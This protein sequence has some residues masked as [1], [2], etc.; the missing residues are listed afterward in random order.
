MST[1][2]TSRRSSQPPHTPLVSTPSRPERPPSPLSPTRESRNDEKRSMQNLNDRLA[3]YIEAVR[4]REAEIQGLKQERT[5]IEETHHT[6][7]T[8]IKTTYNK[9]IGVLRKALDKTSSENSRLQLAADKGDRESQEAKSELV[10]KAR[11][12]EI[13][14]REHKILQESFSKLKNKCNNAENELKSLKPENES[15]KKRLDETKKSLEDET[16]KRVDL[17]NE[18]LSKEESMKFENQMLEQQLNE[19]KTKK[20]IEISELD[21]RLNEQY[22]A[23]MQQSLNE[24]RD[25]YE[26]QIDGNQKEFQRVY[27]DKLKN[28]Q[29]RLDAERLNNAGSIQEVRELTTKITALTNRNVE[30]ESSNSSLQKRMTELQREMDDLAARTRAE[31]ARKDA[32]VRNKEE[33][34]DLMT[35]DYKDLMEIK[36]ALDMEIAAYRKLLEGEE[37]R[38]GLSPA[39]SPEAS[40]SGP[41]RKRKRTIFEEEVILEMVSEH[42]G[43]GNVTI[44]PVTKGANN[45]CIKNN[46]EEDLNIGGWSLVNETKGEEYSYKFPARTSLK[47][48]ELCTVWSADSDQEHKPPLNLVFK[49]GGWIIGIENETKLIN[50]DG[51]DVAV[52]KSHE[53]KREVSAK[54]SYRARSSDDNNKSCAMM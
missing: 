35:K 5:T 48:G 2:R 17:Q 50:K 44:E 22:E 47:P 20:Q 18:L 39:G 31:M 54:R 4:N 46:S 26:K 24:L 30:L 6:E 19:T 53:E 32:E 38:L 1:K 12:L 7:I 51:E 45:I 13:L 3:S 25:T 36:V 14:D 10:T 40:I 21:G 49:K 16:L 42:F 33:Q 23:K 28:L 43:E 8:Q 29:D 15:L 9:E 41:P 27:E 11:D 34:M 37:A 52:R